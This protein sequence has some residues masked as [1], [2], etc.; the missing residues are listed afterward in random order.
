MSRNRKKRRIPTSSGDACRIDKKSAVPLFGM[1]PAP[2][3]WAL[4]Q[5]GD[6]RSPRDVRA[7]KQRINTMKGA[8]SRKRASAEITEVAHATEGTGDDA[9][10]TRAGTV[11]TVG[12]T[13][14][15]SDADTGAEDSRGDV[16]H[17]HR[18]P[19]PA[20][21]TL[22]DVKE[23]TLRGEGEDAKSVERSSGW[24]TAAVGSAQAGGQPATVIRTTHGHSAR[25][26]R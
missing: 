11:G 2:V 10:E 13:V 19:N 8:G 23:A 9:E 22:V 16:I 17:R 6:E 14:E 26:L 18:V 15:T 4:S 5:G 21:A 25:A 3:A 12:V 7:K 20:V 1:R 24:N